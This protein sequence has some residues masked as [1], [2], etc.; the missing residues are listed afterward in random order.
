MNFSLILSNAAIADTWV[1]PHYR[2]DGTYVPGHFR[3]NPN[4]TNWDNFSSK[5]NQNPFSGRRGHQEL[6]R[7]SGLSNY[8]NDKQIHTGPRGGQY[9]YNENGKKVYTK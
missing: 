6:D 3:T 7:P 9:Y 5:G 4:S 1:D 2:K 8:G